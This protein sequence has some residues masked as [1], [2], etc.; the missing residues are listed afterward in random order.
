MAALA[1]GDVDRAVH[2]PVGSGRLGTLVGRSVDGLARSISER[3]RLQRRLAHEASHDALTGLANRRTALSRIDGMLRNDSD[4]DLLFL[5]LDG[6]Q[7]VNDEHGHGAGYELLVRTADPLAAGTTR[8]QPVGRH[9]G[10][11]RRV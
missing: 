3:D 6:F 9:G 10:D 5:D 4:V 7:A 2:G 11:G 1:S 8:A